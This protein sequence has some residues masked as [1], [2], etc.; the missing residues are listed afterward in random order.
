MGCWHARTIDAAQNNSMLAPNDSVT[1]YRG[2]NFTNCQAASGKSHD[3]EFHGAS[4][5]Q[6]CWSCVLHFGPALFW[7]DAEMACV[8]VVVCCRDSF[9]GIS[10]YLKR[11]L[12]Q[13]KPCFVQQRSLRL[14]ALRNL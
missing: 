7:D 11:E 14:I 1:A 6:V 2:F 10:F 8:D 4:A 3:W 12:S 13:R 5:D 9:F